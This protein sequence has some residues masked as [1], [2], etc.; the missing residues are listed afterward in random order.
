MSELKY[1]LTI[2]GAPV[3]HQVDRVFTLIQITKQV[4]ME[5]RKSALQMQ[6]A[7][8][9]LGNAA[10]TEANAVIGI[11]VSSAAVE[12]EGVPYLYFTYIGTPAVISP[13]EE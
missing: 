13:I 11:R 5:A 3:G 8:D 12:I 10:P 2:E 6:D 1:L 9:E 7:L 4:K